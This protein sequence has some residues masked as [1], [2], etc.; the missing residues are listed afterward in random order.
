MDSV[1]LG[2]IHPSRSLLVD[3]LYI[4]SFDDCW[5][6][7][8]GDDDHWPAIDRAAVARYFSGVFAEI[9]HE[10]GGFETIVPLEGPHRGMVIRT[11]TGDGFNYV[12]VANSVA[13]AIEIQIRLAERG[14]INS[15]ASRQDIVTEFT[16]TPD[17]VLAAGALNP[18]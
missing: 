2:G 7:A 11:V 4:G 12:P 14:L 9:G 3:L 5:R 13:E 17:D 1:G 15:P 16:G 18:V 6:S 8:R 10:A